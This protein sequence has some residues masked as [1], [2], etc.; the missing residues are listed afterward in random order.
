MA[1]APSS[2]AIAEDL[3]L[4]DTRLKQLKLEYDQYFL[5]TRPR[6]PVLLRGDVQ[7]LVVKYSNI[8]IQNTALRFKFNNLCGRFFALR[9]QWDA[10][11]RQIEEGTY[12]RHVFKAKL[13]DHSDAAAVAAG[14]E[15]DAA[16]TGGDSGD[17]FEAYLEARRSCGEGTGGMTR[18]RLDRVL[19]QQRAAIAARYGCSEVR[20]RVVVEGGRARLKAMPVRGDRPA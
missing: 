14:G 5:G 17:L 4:L 15:G 2:T 16:P 7:K 12:T 19:A 6:E 8:G 10:T 9:R 13:H 20:F 3:Q 1:D 11:L 18:E